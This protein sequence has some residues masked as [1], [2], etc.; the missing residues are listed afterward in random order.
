MNTP[1]KGHHRKYLSIKD[2]F[3]GTKNGLSYG[4]EERTMNS[5]LFETYLPEF[6]WRK[7]FHFKTFSNFL[8]CIK[9]QYKFELYKVTSIQSFVFCVILSF[10]LC[11]LSFVSSLIFSIIMSLICVSWSLLCVINMRVLR[12]RKRVVPI[13]K[14]SIVSL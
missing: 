10:V 6:M 7:K 2:T 8:S 9:E 12:N 1:N 11:V 4:N 3:G 14:N 13:V 5:Q